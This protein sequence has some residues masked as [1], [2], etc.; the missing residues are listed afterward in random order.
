MSA[1]LVPPSKHCLHKRA[2]TYSEITCFFW[3]SNLQRGKRED[4][5][6]EGGAGC[7]NSLGSLTTGTCVPVLV[8]GNHIACV[9]KLRLEQPE[10]RTTTSIRGIIAMKTLRFLQICG[11]IATSLC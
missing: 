3:H 6:E 5:E 8:P 7:I 9:R 2:T 10:H 11:T 1:L 4:K